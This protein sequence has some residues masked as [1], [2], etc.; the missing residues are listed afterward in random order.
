MST[1]LN[2]THVGDC[3]ALLQAMAADEVS[4]QCVVTS[5]PYWGLRD[6]G[7]DGAIGLEPTLGEWLRTMI[8]C[9][10]WVRDVLVQDGTLW[11]NLGDSYANG[12]RGGNPTEATS[13]LHGGQESQRASMVK[14][15]LAVPDGLKPK[16][17]MGQPWRVALALQDDGWWLRS[18][19]V[20]HKSNPMPESVYDRP[21]KCH[22]Y[23]FLLSRSERYHYDA[24]AI[25]DPATGNAH[26]RHKP[27]AGH[28][29]GPGS[30]GPK[31]HARRKAG[32]RDSTKF[33]RGAGWRVAGA[34]GDAVT[35]I[36]KTRNARTVWT[37]PTQPFGGA[38][39]ATFPRGPGGALHPRGVT[40]RRYRARSVHG[41][42]HGRESCH[43]P[44][45]QLHRLRDQSRL[46][47]T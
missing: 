10:R 40:P 4:V 47:A 22:E 38:H 33:G 30:H 15:S 6:Y 34:F 28:Q 9:F 37:I 7:V 17:L 26:P 2:R 12:G 24:G 44:R 19:I 35:E 20:W 3:R 25:A 5:P 41:F 18:D 39:F 21:T 11:L 1:W 23:V 36:Q 27:V 42:W 32:L 31:D 16:D 43:G 45:P 46:R 14:R 29:H 8:V 13:G